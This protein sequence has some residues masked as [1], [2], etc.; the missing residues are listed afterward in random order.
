MDFYVCLDTSRVTLNLDY[1][2]KS[3]WISLDSNVHKGFYTSCYCY[4]VVKNW[5]DSAV[6]KG[7]TS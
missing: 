1:E 5:R 2:L 4:A 7:A 3:E 6:L